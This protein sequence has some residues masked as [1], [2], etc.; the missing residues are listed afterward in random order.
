VVIAI[1]RKQ[2]TKM[3]RLENEYLFTDEPD[4]VTQEARDTQP[5]ASGFAV[6]GSAASG[7]SDTTKKEDH[8]YKKSQRSFELKNDDATRRPAEMPRFVS[9]QALDAVR[10]IAGG[11]DR[12]FLPH[13]FMDWVAGKEQPRDMDK[14]FLA[15]VKSFTKGKPLAWPNCQNLSSW[16]SGVSCVRVPFNLDTSTQVLSQVFRA[17]LKDVDPDEVSVSAIKQH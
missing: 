2:D 9:E 11:W 4:G 15:W 12:Q 5:T 1:G 7:K 8:K 6:S 10:Q 17:A 13:R 14:A 16:R 3:E